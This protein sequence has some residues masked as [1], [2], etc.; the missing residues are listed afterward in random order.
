MTWLLLIHENT[1]RIIEFV[2][3]LTQRAPKFVEISAAFLIVSFDHHQLNSNHV[4]RLKQEYYVTTA[5]AD[6]LAPSTVLGHLQEQW[7]P[8]LCLFVAWE[9][10]FRIQDS[11]QWYHI[12]VMG[13]HI[14]NP[15]FISFFNL[16]MTSSNGHIFRDIPRFYGIMLCWAAW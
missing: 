7:W 14:T 16:M 9:M 11:F 4:D 13:S 6:G 1:L 10:Q 12:R 2:Q 5:P 3:Q 8:S 15:L